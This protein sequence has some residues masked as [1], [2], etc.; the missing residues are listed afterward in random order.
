MNTRRS[1]GIC[2]SS[3]F[4]C[5][6]G[7]TRLRCWLFGRSGAPANTPWKQVRLTRGF[8]TSAANLAMKAQMWTG[9][10]LSQFSYDDILYTYELVH[11]GN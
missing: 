6:A 1:T 4:P 8:G 9:I 11:S 10:E 3:T 2:G 5:L 7:V